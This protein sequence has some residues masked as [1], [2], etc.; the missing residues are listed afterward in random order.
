VASVTRVPGLAVILLIRLYQ[1][2]VG[3][4]LTPRCRFH[5]SCSEYAVQAIEMHGLVRGAPRAAWRLLRC[6][7]WSAGGIDPVR[8]SAGHAEAARG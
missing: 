7:P 4:L 5:P 8:P 2:S 6:G 3:R 1:H